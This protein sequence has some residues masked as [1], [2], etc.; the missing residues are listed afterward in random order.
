MGWWPVAGGW[1]EGSGALAV[2]LQGLAC[3]WVV[4]GAQGS[5][6]P[7]LGP[8]SPSTLDLPESPPSLGIASQDASSLCTP[9]TG[10]AP[11]VSPRPPNWP[12]SAG[13]CPRWFSHGLKTNGPLLTGCSQ[14]PRGGVSGTDPSRP[15][16]GMWAHCWEFP[17]P[18]GQVGGLL[19]ATCLG[20]DFPFLERRVRTWPTYLPGRGEAADSRRVSG[21]RTPCQGPTLVQVPG[22]ILRRAPPPSTSGL[23]EIWARDASAR[24]GGYF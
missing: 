20:A 10:L 23:G 2:G 17:S 16:P 1:R 14:G 9:S 6:H 21:D 4:R 22:H 24:L 7:G 19:P 13:R 3:P 12:A 8:P 11:W 15:E 5:V 18:M